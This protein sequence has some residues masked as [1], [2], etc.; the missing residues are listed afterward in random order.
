LPATFVPHFF[1][2]S[3]DYAWFIGFAVAFILYLLFRNLS[4]FSRPSA[5]A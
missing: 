3:Y 2:S 4:G 5:S 1:I